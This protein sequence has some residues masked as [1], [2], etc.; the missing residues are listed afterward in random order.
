ME[1]QTNSEFAIGD[2]IV[3][4]ERGFSSEGRKTTA[5]I[6]EVRLVL[7]KLSYTVETEGGKRRVVGASQ[8]NRASD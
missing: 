5:K 7:G 3:L 4:V 2:E 6:V 8:V 1:Q